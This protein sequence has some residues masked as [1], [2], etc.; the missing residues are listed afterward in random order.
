MSALNYPHAG[1]I[2][3]IA[4]AN[5]RVGECG[6]NKNPFWPFPNNRTGQDIRLLLMLFWNV[7][8]ALLGIT[9]ERTGSAILSLNSVFL[10][11]SY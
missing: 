1:L 10:S 5:L 6:L 8:H 9:C 2:V 11:G 3:L 4:A 7:L